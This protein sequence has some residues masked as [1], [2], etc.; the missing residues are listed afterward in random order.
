MSLALP[1]ANN[2]SI[3]FLPSQKTIRSVAQS[4]AGLNSG[5]RDAIGVP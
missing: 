5:P 2:E 3:N 4:H 1:V